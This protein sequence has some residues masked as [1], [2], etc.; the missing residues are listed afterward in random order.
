VKLSRVRPP[1]SL[2]ACLSHQLTA[3]AACGGFAAVARRAGDIDRLLHGQPSAAT[4]S[5]VTLSADVG[6]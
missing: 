2:T 6:S 3:A 4:V 1:V 5:S